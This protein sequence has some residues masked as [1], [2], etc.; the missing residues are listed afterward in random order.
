M[1]GVGGEHSVESCGIGVPL[2][3]AHELDVECKWDDEISERDEHDGGEVD[4][5]SKHA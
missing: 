5:V 1:S 2:L 3:F 4:E